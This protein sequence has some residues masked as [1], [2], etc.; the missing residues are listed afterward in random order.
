MKFIPVF[1]FCI[2][3]L[4]CKEAPKEIEKEVE[5]S[6]MSI[7]IID[8]KYPEALQKIFIAHG[9]LPFGC[10]MKKERT[11]EMLFFTII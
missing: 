10:K 6:K 3:M 11:K 8:S 2:V 5:A 1:L 7:N 9:A 4:S